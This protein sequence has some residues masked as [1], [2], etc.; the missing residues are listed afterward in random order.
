[1]SL[2]VSLTQNI[3]PGNVSFSPPAAVNLLS[4]KFLSLMSSGQPPPPPPLHHSFTPLTKIKSLGWGRLAPDIFMELGWSIIMTL[5]HNVHKLYP[6]SWSHCTSREEIASRIVL[7]KITL[8][9]LN[10]PWEARPH[11]RGSGRLRKVLILKLQ[12]YRP[13][14]FSNVS[15]GRERLL[16]FHIETHLG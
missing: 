6:L 4:V 13:G 14:D 16:G 1:M 11:H 5:W 12:Q 2:C 8:E 15:L 7:A 9:R 3:Y 10:T